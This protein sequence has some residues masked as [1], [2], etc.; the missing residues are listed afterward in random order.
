MEPPD[1]RALR[2]DNASTGPPPQS[3]R[4]NHDDI[5]FAPASFARFHLHRRHA[6]RLDSR[7][8]F[9]E[10][11]RWGRATLHPSALRAINGHPE[12]DVAG[13]DS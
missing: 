1:C 10:S 13:R 9:P 3:L 7:S 11:A 2:R 8:G 5:L 4:H 6:G 12:I